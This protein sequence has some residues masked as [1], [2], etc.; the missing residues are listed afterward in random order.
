[1]NCFTH[2]ET[3]AVGICKACCK[4]LCPACA[5]EMDG[6]ISCGGECE[7]YIEQLNKVIRESSTSSSAAFVVANRQVRQQGIILIFFGIAFLAFAYLAWRDGAGKMPWLFAVFGLLFGVF[8][9]VRLR[10]SSMYPIDK[11][12]KESGG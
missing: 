9:V 2:P 4:G 10:R 7:T 5:V 3:A 1:M 8:G 6:A 11:P 12:G